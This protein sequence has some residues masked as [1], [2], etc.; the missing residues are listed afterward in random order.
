MAAWED[1]LVAFTKLN[2]LILGLGD[3][4]VHRKELEADAHRTLHTDVT[5]ALLVIRRGSRPD[6]RPRLVGA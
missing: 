1:G 4:H 2:A 3:D 5:A 6:A